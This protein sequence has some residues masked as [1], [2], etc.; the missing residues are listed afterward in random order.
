MSWVEVV[1]VSMMLLVEES[2]LSEDEKIGFENGTCLLVRTD[3]KS[4]GW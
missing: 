4:V 1:K 3:P 2:K